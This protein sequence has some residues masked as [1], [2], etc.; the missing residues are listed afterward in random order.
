MVLCGG[1]SA[2]EGGV[3]AVLFAPVFRR[4]SCHAP[5]VLAGTTPS[6]TPAFAGVIRYDMA[7]LFMGHV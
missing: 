4:D 2:L 3:A 1:V 6:R 7:W 5:T